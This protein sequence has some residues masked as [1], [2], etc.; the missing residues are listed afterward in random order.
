MTA[1]IIGFPKSKKQLELETMEQYVSNAKRV[2]V[3]NEGP[4]VNGVPVEEPKTRLAYLNLCKKFLEPEDYQDILC[5]I[6]DVEHYD[7]L[8]WQLQNVINSYFSF[9]K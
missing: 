2:I 4:N 3:S 5:G 6:M 8:E 1:Q 7:A 9:N